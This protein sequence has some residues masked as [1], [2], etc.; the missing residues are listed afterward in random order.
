MSSNSWRGIFLFTFNQIYSEIKFQK[1]LHMSN[2]QPTA[3]V[4]EVDNCG[5][6]AVGRCAICGRAFCPTHQGYTFNNFYQRIPYL[7]SCSPCVDAKRVE[8]TKRQAEAWEKAHA[9][10]NYFNW[11]EVMEAVKR[12]TGASSKHLGHPRTDIFFGTEDIS[13]Y[14]TNFSVSNENL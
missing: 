4:C 7:D 6:Q 13:Q 11:Q 2:T 5:V 14:S 8:E 10:S 1:G 12:L 3:A 9:P